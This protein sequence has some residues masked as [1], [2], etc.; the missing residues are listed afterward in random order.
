MALP[1]SESERRTAPS[2]VDVN[3]QSWWRTR[4]LRDQEPSQLLCGN[5]P[6][7][8]AWENRTMSDP[9]W[10]S[11]ETY[12]KLQTAEAPDFAWE[13]FRRNSNC[14]K[15]YRTRQNSGSIS[16]PNMCAICESD[17][18]PRCRDLLRGLFTR[19]ANGRVKTVLKD[20]GPEPRLKCVSGR[21]RND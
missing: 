15:D 5:C 9:D 13:C 20:L 16:E 17:T 10:R 4:G 11:P 7:L 3:Y 6:V 14:R 2:C 8:N 19:S 1:R 12:A 18:P 21:D